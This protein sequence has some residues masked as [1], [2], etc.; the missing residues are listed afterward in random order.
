VNT[1]TPQLFVLNQEL[2]S[3]SGDLWIQDENGN[4]LYEVDGKAFSL[5]RRH[6]LLDASGNVLYEI[7]QALAH[8]RR[9]FEIKRHDQVVATVQQ[10]ILTFLGDRFSVTLADGSE[11]SIRGDIIDREFHATRDGREVILASRRLISV[12]D[13]YGVRVAPEFDAALALAI[14]IALEQMELQARQQAS[15]VRSH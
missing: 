11:L 4:R 2:L 3:L 6:E 1:E 5:R 13:S 9:T 8:V 14:V 7:A 15:Q 12:R 10:A